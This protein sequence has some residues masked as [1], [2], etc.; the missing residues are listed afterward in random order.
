MSGS[1]RNDARPSTANSTKDMLAAGSGVA[2]MLRNTT[3][4]GDI[5]S[6]PNTSRCLPKTTVPQEPP[7]RRPSR[8][9]SGL[10]LSRTSSHYSR[11]G[12]IR[13]GKSGRSVMDPNMPGAWPY[14][15]HPYAASHDFHANHSD[16]RS[17]VAQESVKSMPLRPSDRVDSMDRSYS[18]TQALPPT[19]ALNNHR[20]MTS[21]KNQEVAPRPRSPFG[22]PPR[23]TP[24]GYRPSSPA[25]SD[26]A[27]SMYSRRHGNRP[28]HA[29]RAYTA[30]PMPYHHPRRFAGTGSMPG[31]G[32]HPRQ[33]M[34]KRFVDEGRRPGAGLYNTPFFRG[35]DASRPDSMY[36]RSP[37]TPTVAT[38]SS[39]LPGV[40][41]PLSSTPPPENAKSKNSPHQRRPTD[42][43]PYAGFVQRVKNVLEERI[44]SEEQPRQQVPE[45]I[46]EPNHV[47][48]TIPNAFESRSG[49]V[50]EDIKEENEPPSSPPRSAAEQDYPVDDTSKVK[51]LTR[52]MV[53]AAFD[54]QSDVDGESE[55]MDEKPPGSALEGT[56]DEEGER[57]NKVADDLESIAV[58]VMD[59]S[60]E[61]ARGLPASKPA[62]EDVGTFLE[63]TPNRCSVVPD[64]PSD[65][66]FSLQ[67]PD[68]VIN[69]GGTPSLP[70]PDARRPDPSS[71]I[72]P[73]VFAEDTNSTNYSNRP[74]SAPHD[75][76]TERQE[77]RASSTKSLPMLGECLQSSPPSFTDEFDIDVQEPDQPA[78]KISKLHTSEV[79]E[80][81]EETQQE[82]EGEFETDNVTQAP[83][84]P[85]NQPTE[86]PNGELLE[87]SD[88]EGPAVLTA[89]NT[90]TTMSSAPF[91]GVESPRFS[92]RRPYP[93]NSFAG[94]RPESMPP[95]S[96]N[97]SGSYDARPSA[98][99][100]FQFPLPDLTEDSQEDA[101]TTNL[102]MLGA[103]GPGF[104]PRFQ[105]EARAKA[106][107][108]HRRSTVPNSSQSYFDRPPADTNDLPTLNFSRQ[109]LTSTLNDALGIR[110][111]RSL[112]ELG[113][114]AKR[115]SKPDIP[116]R[117]RSSAVRDERYKSF[118]MLTDEDSETVFSSPGS[119]L[120]AASNLDE[121]FL[122]EIE[123]LSIPSVRNLT[124]RLSELLPSIKR[125]C[126]DLDFGSVDD[127]VRE[128]VEEI[129]EIGSPER[130]AST[131]GT[132]YE[133]D[134]DS[135]QEDVPMK[136]PGPDN[137]TSSDKRNSAQ[138][139]YL[140][141]MK[142]LPPLPMG[143]IE[144]AG[145]MNEKLG[146][147]ASQSMEESSNGGK[148]HPESS[149]TQQPPNGSHELP[150]TAT[151][152]FKLKKSSMQAL[153]DSPS[154][155][156]PWTKDENYPWANGSPA[157]D[158]SLSGNAQRD[159]NAP[160]RKLKL[161]RIRS[162]PE[163][164][165]EETVR[166]ARTMSPGLRF[167]AGLIPTADLFS[168]DD[169]PT[170]KGGI[171]SS[172]SRK[173]GL[174]PKFDQS[175]FPMDPSFLHP[176][177]RSVSPGDRY[178]TT[179]LNPPAGYHFDESRSFFSDDSSE[180]EHARG[181]RHRLT[182]MRARRAAVGSA[183]PVRT[184]ANFYQAGSTEDS[185]SEE[186]TGDVDQ[187]NIFQQARAPGGMS[188]AEFH[189]RRLVEKLITLLYRS[190]EAVRRNLHISK[191][192]PATWHSRNND[193]Y[194][195]V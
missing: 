35:W 131:G 144:T 105:R 129:R 89:E 11:N 23:L 106:R 123:R 140:R 77:R 45:Q 34:H 183:S 25:L 116:E 176:G 160:L 192:Q 22:L 79:N 69:Q 180:S 1:H 38:I 72:S 124:Q 189:A 20:S 56:A 95:H 185:T 167:N 100:N 145:E 120:G 30:S 85:I 179:A 40:S 188:N 33:L 146:V 42:S 65:I 64:T 19:H 39:H 138:R 117:A 164:S 193:L 134:T 191:R 157:V 107:H 50:I 92:N 97:G 24:P 67:L 14:G 102:R 194:Q 137:G 166:V 184:R 28:P 5:G 154:T 51:R 150:A 57:A 66:N 46:W 181:L 108:P 127:A 36:H 71:E 159:E 87:T 173:I 155:P 4:I 88:V 93:R 83:A 8:K 115:A 177:E 151:P 178:P 125:S 7:G 142:E 96:S 29:P 62:E 17:S 132:Y 165:P 128:T 10:A 2:S 169:R 59:R 60:V 174:S 133:E 32:P 195:G 136:Q 58:Q 163:H 86:G 148:L 111:S 122:D 31:P 187:G 53:K 168:G 126:S 94:N 63:D 6:F 73:G 61:M 21:L 121:D 43:A 153:R 90:S 171:F 130:L 75:R 82:K 15:H 162:N 109:D 12:S 13:S 52:D 26:T 70:V 41:P 18:M 147:N 91:S 101:S 118:F 78:Q 98:V 104:R 9:P 149:V 139:R 175:G 48:G 27:G 84:V 112:E 110:R 68:K 54:T 114:P 99:K 113:T 161:K 190:S 37:V 170:S 103:R 156:R 47:H 172:L 3:E 74:S 182:R 49:A 16:A 44:S 143:E 76:V 119:Q 186:S 141:L 152:K 135:D 158:V 55:S 81:A 80:G